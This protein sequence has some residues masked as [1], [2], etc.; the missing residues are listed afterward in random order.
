MKYLARVAVLSILMEG[1]IAGIGLV[2]GWEV[3]G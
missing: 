3:D 2:D 1:N